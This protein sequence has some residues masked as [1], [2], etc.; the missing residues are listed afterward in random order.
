[1]TCYRED[2]ERL[3]SEA[4]VR[5]WGLRSWVGAGRVPVGRR[6]SL[7]PAVFLLGSLVCSEP[8][9]TVHLTSRRRSSS[10]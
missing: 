3:P 8:S 9:S 10:K 2:L 7:S 4:E 1:M 5:A 6:A